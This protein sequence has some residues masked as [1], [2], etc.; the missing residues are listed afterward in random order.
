MHGTVHGPG[1]SGGNGISAAY[2]LPYGQR[3]ADEFHVYAAEW[4][5]QMIRFFVD[6]HK[7]AEVTPERLPKDTPW[8]YDHPF[9]L[10]LNLA[11]GG[12]WLVT[13]MI[14]RFFPQVMLVDWIRIWQ[15]RPAHRHCLLKWC[16]SF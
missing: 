9:F 16:F 6:G 13:P 15:E 11:V 5:P 4:Q 1:Y 3:F 14:Q 8:V 10:L 12:D 2:T 7:Y